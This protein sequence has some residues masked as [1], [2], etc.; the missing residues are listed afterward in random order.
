MVPRSP[1]RSPVRSVI[2]EILIFRI[3]GRHAEDDRLDS[4][5]APEAVWRAGFDV[6]YHAGLHID[7]VA[8][9]FH[10]ATTLQNVVH[11]SALL[12]VVPDGVGYEGDVQVTGRSI[13][14]GERPRALSAGT[15]N[16]RS[17]LK[18]ADD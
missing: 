17:V 13:R 8:G 6:D 3:Q 5:R 11:L 9:Q 12:V 18:A 1:G 14:T 15:G 4:V 7:H 10:L 2:S 16:R